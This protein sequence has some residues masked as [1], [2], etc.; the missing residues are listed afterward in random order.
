M[1]ACKFPFFT[2]MVCTWSDVLAFLGDHLFAKCPGQPASFVGM[3]YVFDGASF[4]DR[5]SVAHCCWN[6]VQRCCSTINAKLT[7][8]ERVAM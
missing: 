3:K 1:A 6:W 5:L 4:E 2:L 7:Q 8:L